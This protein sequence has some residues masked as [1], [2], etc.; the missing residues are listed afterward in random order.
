VIPNEAEALWKASRM[1]SL[2]WFRA[3]VDLADQVNE[4]NT[5]DVDEV[6]VSIS[7]DEVGDDRGDVITW[8]RVEGFSWIYGNNVKESVRRTKLQECESDAQN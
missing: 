3:L 6:S 4:R 8:S 1:I 7:I 5:V 2:P